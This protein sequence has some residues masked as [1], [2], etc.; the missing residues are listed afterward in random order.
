MAEEKLSLAVTFLQSHPSSAAAILEQHGVDQVAAFLESIPAPTAA[1]VV[2]FLLPHYAARVCNILEPER[3][4]SLFAYSEIGTVAAI[5]RHF[6]KSDRSLILEQLPTKL[7]LACSLLLNYSQEMVGAWITPQVAT[8]PDNYTV[9]E[10][11]NYLKNTEDIVHTDSIFSITRD[12]EFRGRLKWVE[13]IKAAGETPVSN[14]T[15]NKGSKLRARLR[16]EEAATHNDWKRFHEIPVINRN[17]KFIGV[18]CHTDLRKG[19]EHLIPNL[20]S[21]TQTVSGE[22]LVAAYSESIVAALS[23]MLE[24]VKSEIPS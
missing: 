14:L 1:K 22:N 9:D 23:S 10:A 2:Q 6:S 8:V 4:H 17:Q 16:L 20:K 15:E 18:L 24:I 3:L 19:L 5:L 7:Q 13:L 12:R 11:I 21:N